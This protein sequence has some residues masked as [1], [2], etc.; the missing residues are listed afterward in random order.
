MAS[1]MFLK[2]DGID[3]ESSDDKHS[4]EI[5]VLSYS[6]GVRQQ[7]SG[8]ASSAGN[9]ST[10]RADFQDFSIVKAIDKDLRVTD[11]GDGSYTARK[12][13]VLRRVR[14]RE[15]LHRFNRFDR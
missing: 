2:V 12:F 13:A 10:G 5:E 8:S 9:L 7:R 15:H 11:N 4:G 14:I 6:W 3:G 1:D